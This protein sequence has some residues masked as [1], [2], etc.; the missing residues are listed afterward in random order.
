MNSIYQE[1][2]VCYYDKYLRIFLCQE[3]RKYLLLN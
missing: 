2:I 3:Y 1:S